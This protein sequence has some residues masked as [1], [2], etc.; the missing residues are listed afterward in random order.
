[1]SAD[2]SALAT[3]VESSLRTLRAAAAFTGAATFASIRDSAGR[4]GSSSP[5]CSSSSSG[6]RSSPVFGSVTAFLLGLLSRTGGNAAAAGDPGSGGRFPHVRGD[7]RIDVAHEINAVGR[8]PDTPLNDFSDLHTSGFRPEKGR[9]NTRSHLGHP[10]GHSS[11]LGCLYPFEL[12]RR[13]SAGE[14]RLPRSFPR[15]SRAAVRRGRVP[16]AWRERADPTGRLSRTRGGA[17]P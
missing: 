17:P 9:T 7:R 13:G 10:A 2:C 3:A 8:A 6:V 1:M 11:P 5:S 12:I 15:P 16:A 14:L 4:S